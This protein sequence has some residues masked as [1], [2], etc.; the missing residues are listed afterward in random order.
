MSILF[1]GFLYLL[2]IYLLIY[3]P[4]FFLL[5]TGSYIVPTCFNYLFLLSPKYQDQTIQYL[6]TWG[7]E[8]L[9]E[10]DDKY[11]RL[12]LTTGCCQAIHSHLFKCLQGTLNTSFG[13]SGSQHLDHGNLSA[14]QISRLPSTPNHKEYRGCLLHPSRQ[15]ALACSTQ[16]ASVS[17]KGASPV[18]FGI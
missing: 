9:L 13:V 10:R 18:P 7:T 15:H 12:Y 6:C 2:T 3:L 1:G 8:V 5:K 4:F 14:E 16:K 17:E 11:V